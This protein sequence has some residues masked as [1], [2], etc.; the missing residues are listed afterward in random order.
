MQSIKKS[1]EGQE[2]TPNDERANGTEREFS[3]MKRRLEE[4]EQL[5][6]LKQPMEKQRKPDVV[7]EAPQNH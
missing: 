1:E 7:P 3:E 2:V 6:S 4:L 5:L